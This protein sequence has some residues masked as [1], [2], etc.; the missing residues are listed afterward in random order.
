MNLKYS[1]L[2][3]LFFTCVVIPV[4][5]Q[6]KDESIGLIR[7]IFRQTNAEKN[8]TAIKIENEELTGEVPDGGVSITGY[9]KDQSLLKISLWTGLSYG[10]QETEYY[11][12]NDTLI[13]AHVTEKHFRVNA[14]KV[15]YSKVD[16][17]FEGR[18]YYK[19]NELI[20]KITKGDG[21]WNSSEEGEKKLP[22]D[23]HNYAGLLYIKRN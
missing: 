17:K 14:D 18:Y 21:F 3:F 6:T 10:I 16:L 12:T 13:F 9:F 23:S 20:D 5:A 1:I 22:V 8:L 19:N 2:L 4:M 7:K 15:D 11:F